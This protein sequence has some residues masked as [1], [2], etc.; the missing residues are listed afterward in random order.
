MALHFFAGEPM[1]M[2]A[3]ADNA[4]KH[5]LLD[6]QAADAPAR[7][8]RFRSGHHAPPCVVRHYGQVRVHVWR[9]CRSKLTY[10]VTVRHSSRICTRAH[11]GIINMGAWP[12]YAAKES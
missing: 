12:W 1:L 9:A 5:W 7:L 10:N 4:L 8:L 2:S 11:F 6:G 3:G